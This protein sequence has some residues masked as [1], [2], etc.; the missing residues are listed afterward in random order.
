[1]NPKDTINK[2]GMHTINLRTVGGD[3]R[4]VTVAIMITASSHQLPLLVVFK[5]KSLYCCTANSVSNIIVDCCVLAAR[6]PNGTIAR[7]D[8]PTLPAGIVYHLNKKAW[9]N[10]QIMLDWVEH[11]LAPYIAMV[12]PGIVPILLLDQFRVHKMGSIINAI[13]ALDVQVEFIPA[14]CTRLVQPVNIGYNKSFK[15][16][17]RNEFLAWMMLQ[18]PNVLIPGST[19]HDVF[20][21]I[22]NTQNNISAKMIGNAWR[23]TGFSYH[24]ENAKI[25]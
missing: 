9:F 12:P 2:R 18:D 20:Q 8:V 1:M 5:G 21:W 24:P 17:I 13:Q 22:I 16:K 10:K 11:V 7:S 15:C 3:S 4:Q 23:K 6:M 19:C 14:G 25:K